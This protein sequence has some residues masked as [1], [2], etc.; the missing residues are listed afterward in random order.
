MCDCDCWTE[1]SKG[2]NKAMR[3]I[4]LEYTSPDTLAAAALIAEF[5]KPLNP[6]EDE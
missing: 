4:R 6:P 2:F 1:F 3:E 5:E